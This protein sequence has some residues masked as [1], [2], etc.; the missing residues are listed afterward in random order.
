MTRPIVFSVLM[1]LPDESGRVGLR[2]V[3]HV[4]HGG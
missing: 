2:F 4:I 1:M 3:V